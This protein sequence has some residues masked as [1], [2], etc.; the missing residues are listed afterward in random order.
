MSSN[1]KDKKNISTISFETNKCMF[2][3]I[4]YNGNV[5]FIFVTNKD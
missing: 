3:D 2:G 1:I 4:G 5:I